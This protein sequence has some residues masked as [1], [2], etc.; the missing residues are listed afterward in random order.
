MKVDRI[1]S[2]LIELGE[3][4]LETLV[5]VAAIHPRPRLQGSEIVRK[6]TRAARGIEN[7]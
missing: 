1:G 6:E 7:L 5:V 4:R 3:D 2:P